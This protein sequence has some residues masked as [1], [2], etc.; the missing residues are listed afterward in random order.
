MEQLVGLG[1]FLSAIIEIAKKFGA[2]PDGYGGLVV[3]IANVI[4]FA[5]AEIVIGYFG[6]DFSTIDGLLRMLAQLLLAVFASFATHK[7]A[8]AMEL[9]VFR[10]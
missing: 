6:V 9:P 2:I 10:K 5:V 8:R 1:A 7:V 4:V 3:A